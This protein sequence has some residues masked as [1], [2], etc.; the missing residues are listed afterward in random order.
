VS[1]A[2]TPGETMAELKQRAGDLKAQ[3]QAMMDSGAWAPN[4]VMFTARIR[5]LSRILEEINLLLR[6]PAYTEQSRAADRDAAFRAG[7]EVRRAEIR[8]K[9]E[10]SGLRAA[11]LIAGESPAAG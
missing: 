4:V 5:K 2:K 8:A 11:S 7:R 10:R 3:I 9:R 1:A 6:S